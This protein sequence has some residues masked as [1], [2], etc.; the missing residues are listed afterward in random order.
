MSRVERT[1]GKVFKYMLFLLNPFK[2]KVIHTNCEIHK[3]INF[4]A[5][6]I[7]KNDRYLDAYSFFSDFI[8][9]INEGAFWADQDFKSSDHFYNP[10]REKGL[11]GNRSALSV[12]SEY[13]KEAIK[14]WTLQNTEKAMF[15]LGAA[16]HI[17]QDMTIPQHANIRLLDNHRQYENFI[18]RTYRNSPKFA[19][20]RG[21][22]YLGSIEEFIRCN[23]RNALRIYS[24]LKDIRDSEKRYYTIAKFTLPLAQKTTAG[25]FLRF[26]RDVFKKKV[27][28]TNHSNQKSERYRIKNG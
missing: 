8:T 20:D 1:Y 7:L 6:D 25:C 15:Y 27:R 2:K 16:V 18:R 26:Y 19:V 12:G 24:R 9:N 28:L 10:V 11:F 22:Y 3:Y 13:Y 17:I 5:L 23:A 14:Y 21:G 4:Q